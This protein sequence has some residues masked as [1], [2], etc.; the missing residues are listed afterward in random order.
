MAKY[1]LKDGEARSISAQGA[2]RI[3]AFELGGGQAQI[4]LVIEGPDVKSARVHDLCLM[5]HELPER[6]SVLVRPKNFGTYGS[7]SEVR[8]TVSNAADTVTFPRVLIDAAEDSPERLAELTAQQGRVLLEAFGSSEGAGIT[9][10]AREVRSK[11]RRAEL[12]VSELQDVTAI[13]DSSASMQV[14]TTP[15]TIEATAKYI[16]ALADSFRTFQ[17][18]DGKE[19]ITTHKVDELSAFIAQ[20][21]RAGADRV[22]MRPLQDP[23]LAQ[24]ASLLI[25]VTDSPVTSMLQASR[26]TV[27]LIVGAI[28]RQELELA[29]AS[30]DPQKVALAVIDE[31]VVTQLATGDAR[32]L[33]A[34]TDHVT[35]MLKER[36]S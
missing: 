31:D 35:A 5:V 33:S 7:R 4:E 16:D 6:A 9:E 8:L 34:L 1:T 3:E 32:E 10:S 14:N 17:A 15:E 26:P 11:M 18:T 19:S 25:Y 24:G 22:G 2:L 21:V 36:N 12:D 28:A 23:R 27:V 29:R 20:T 30:S 13:L